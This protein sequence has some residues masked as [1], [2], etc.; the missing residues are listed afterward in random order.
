MRPANTLLIG[1]I[2]GAHGTGGVCKIVSY[3]ES[4]SIFKAGDRLWVETVEAQFQTHEILWVKAHS[5]GALMALRGV[6]DREAAQALR[7]AGLYIEKNR[8][9]VL[10]DGHFYWFEL[11]GLEVYTEGGHFLGRLVSI[12]ATGSNDVYVVRHADQET[13]VPALASVVKRV[14]TAARRME[15]ILPEGL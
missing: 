9:P 14:D 2:V 11:I 8:L 1:R 13:L 12:L 7:G 10:E 3:A 6:V 4:L 15:V 5:K